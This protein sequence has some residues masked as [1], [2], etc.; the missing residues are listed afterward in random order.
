MLNGIFQRCVPANFYVLHYMLVKNQPVP[1]LSKKLVDKANWLI[2]LNVGNIMLKPDTKYIYEHVDGITYARE[3]DKT[4]RKIIG[5]THQKL[6]EVHSIMD[7]ELW[8]NIR[9]SAEFNPALQRAL[10]QCILLYKLTNH[11]EEQYGNSKT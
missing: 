3:F 1:T 6:K 7:A 9:K 11:Y 10:E 8:Y 5:M 4:E 2:I